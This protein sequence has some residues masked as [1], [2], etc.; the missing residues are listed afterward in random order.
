M[1]ILSDCF[2]GPLKMLWRAVI[3]PPLFYTIFP[4]TVNASLLLSLVWH[5]TP[6]TSWVQS[7]ISKANFP[8]FV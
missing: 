8:F 7:L 6:I 1:K 4:A 3:C 2:R 5:T